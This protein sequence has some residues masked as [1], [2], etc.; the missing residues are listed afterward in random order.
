MS[1]TFLVAVQTRFKSA[2]G[3]RQF[4]IIPASLADATVCFL[5]K[6]LA[7]YAFENVLL[8]LSFD[9]GASAAH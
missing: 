9:T 4:A 1:S 7:T 8:H 5:F 6:W 3:A 2:L